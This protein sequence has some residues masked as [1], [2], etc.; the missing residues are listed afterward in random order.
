MKNKYRYLSLL[1]LLIGLGSQCKKKC[2]D[3]SNPD[4]DNYDPC[5]GKNPVSAAF[6]I[7]EVVQFHTIPE[8]WGEVPDTDTI[9]TYG[10]QFTALEDGAEYEWH[11][12]REVLKGKKVYRE[13]FTQLG[14]YP[15][16]LIVKKQPNK[17]CFPNDD[18]MDTVTRMMYAGIWLDHSPV[19]GKFKGHVTNPIDTLTIDIIKTP[20]NTGGIIDTIVVPYNWG[21]KQDDCR[22][23]AGGG[24]GKTIFKRLYFDYRGIITPN[25][26]SA[27][28]VFE[29]KGKANDTL[30][31]NYTEQKTH[32]STSMRVARQFIGVRQY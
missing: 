29:I 24:Y 15:I 2:Y 12:G 28:G 13:N 26:Y 3:P 22:Y 32:E 7:Q 20:I 19:L 11:I 17:A 5:F 21:G 8:G 14:T 4:C 6:K 25:C 16:Q 18:G 1:L 30:V 9:T 10:V 23:A 27:A 31:I